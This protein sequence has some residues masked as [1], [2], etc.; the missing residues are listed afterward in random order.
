MLSLCLNSCNFHPQICI[1]S[2][3]ST[4]TAVVPNYRKQSTLQFWLCLFA[5][6]IFKV[7]IVTSHLS[8]HGY[9]PGM[10]NFSYYLYTAPVGIYKIVMC[11]IKVII[12]P[13][14]CICTLPLFLLLFIVFFLVGL[15]PHMHVHMWNTQSVTK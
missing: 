11:N 7:T 3:Y 8:V 13:P 14:A 10:Q 5:R 2:T 15:E 12:S 9:H 4:Y 6:K 1:S